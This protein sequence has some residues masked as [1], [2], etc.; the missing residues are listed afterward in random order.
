MKNVEPSDK[1]TVIFAVIGLGTK[2]QRDIPITVVCV[3]AGQVYTVATEV[4][5]FPVAYF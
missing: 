4:P 1:H 5:V 3:E 2:L